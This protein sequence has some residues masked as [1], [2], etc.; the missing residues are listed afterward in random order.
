MFSLLRPPR[1][2]KT[3][4]LDILQAFYDINYQDYF[5]FFFK[6]TDAEK[7]AISH[8]QDLI[9]RLDFGLLSKTS[10]FTYLNYVINQFLRNYST[11]LPNKI[12]E[13]EDPTILFLDLLNTISQTSYKLRILIDEHDAPLSLFNNL[14]DKERVSQLRVFKQFFH[15][16]KSNMSKPINF[17]FLV[18]VTPMTLGDI[19]VGFNIVHDITLSQ[20]YNDVIGLTSEDVKIILDYLNLQKHYEYLCHCF[21]GYH[22]G[23]DS[24]SLFCTNQIMEGIDVSYMFTFINNH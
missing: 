1:F 21:N 19:S 5:E 14:T 15:M 22:F 2:G 16:I 12:Q 3:L 23:K 18:G 8:N 10:F 13:K 20:N 9:L 11:I 4:L 6:G 24:K 17:V 7:L